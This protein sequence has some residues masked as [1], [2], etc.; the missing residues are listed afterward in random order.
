MTTATKIKLTPALEC[1]YELIMIDLGDAK[2]QLVQFEKMIAERKGCKT[3]LYGIITVKD[4]LILAI[5]KLEQRMN[6]FEAEYEK[7][8]KAGDLQ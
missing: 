4:E 7:L 2:K 5:D 6:A 1:E 3:G 8:K